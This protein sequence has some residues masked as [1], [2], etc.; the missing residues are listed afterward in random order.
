MIC[1]YSSK[2]C[3]QPLEDDEELSLEDIFL[4]IAKSRPKISLNKDNA[5]S[6]WSWF[7]NEDRKRVRAKDGPDKKQPEAKRQKKSL[8]RAPSTASGTKGLKEFCICRQPEFGFMIG[9]D[10]CGEWFHGK[11]VGLTKRHDTGDIWKCPFCLG[12]K[13]RPP[14]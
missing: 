9:C 5:G 11:C 6:E 12:K 10:T 7:E 14:L 3:L 1:R 2:V 4:G 13:V 8:K